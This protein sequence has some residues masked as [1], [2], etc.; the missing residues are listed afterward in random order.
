MPQPGFF[1]LDERYAKLNER[2]PLVKLNQIIDWEAFR[3]PLSVIRNKP[4]KSQAGRKP[5]DVVLMFK[6]LVLQHLYNVSDDDI[7]Y[8]IRD[9]HSF[10]R[11]LGR[12]LEDKIPD[13]KTIW[14]FR[15]QLTRH[16][17]HETLFE[18]F[19]QQLVS[20][21]CRAQKGQIV[22][23][24][25]VDVPRQ[26]NSREENAQIKAGETPERFEAN[27]SVKAQ[28]DTDARWAKKNQETHFGYKNHISIDNKHKL[29]RAYE[30]TSAEVHDSQKLLGVLSENTSRDLWADSAYRS[31]ANEKELA[32]RG[33][34]SHIHKKGQRN[35]PL[36]EAQQRANTRKS[37]VRVRVEHVFGSMTNEQGGLYFRVIGL[38]RTA[39]K[40]GLMNLVYNMRRLVQIDKLRASGV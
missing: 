14:L 11:F 6:I 39:T 3:E 19:D 21:G 5:Y 13:A 33:L 10:C 35:K 7:E 38:A 20:Q 23:A 28:K 12:D 34:R 4:R 26:R 18:R 16:E 40:I 37:K 1:D 31:Q 22:D 24:S 27:L 15:E 8:Q 25:F 32:A 29:I 17:L 30:V 2:D 9:R 36:S